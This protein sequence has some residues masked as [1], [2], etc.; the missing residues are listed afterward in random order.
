MNPVA[1]TLFGLEIRWYGLL[2]AIGM[3]V[4]VALS[5]F[6][7]KWRKIDFDSLLDVALLGIPAGLIGARLYYV[8]MDFDEYKDNLLD[9]F[10]VREGGLAI[11][12]GVIFALLVSY[13]YC[14]RKKY[15]FWSMADVAA[16]SIILAQAIGRWGN[17]IN[18]EVYGKAIV[19]VE[20]FKKLMPEFIQEGMYING[21]YHHPTFLY[22]SL[23]NLLV[24]IILLILMKKNKKKGIVVFSYMGLYSIARFYLESMRVESFILKVGGMSVAQIVSVIGIL[25]W[26]GFLIY[27]YVYK[28]NNKDNNKTA[29]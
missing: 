6:T 19:N 1:F 3:L 18:R 21:E 14:R 25:L 15:D 17:F 12:G 10:K 4:A 7:C 20:L 29:D 8:I 2:I 11:H 16:P 24:C 23:W 5:S 13:L 9:I 27:T 26:I 28:G 22:E